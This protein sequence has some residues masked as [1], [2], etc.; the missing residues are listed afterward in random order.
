[1]GVLV[2]DE[3]EEKAQALN[4]ADESLRAAMRVYRDENYTLEQFFTRVEEINDDEELLA[5]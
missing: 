2:A 3:M 1:M 5:P 4:L